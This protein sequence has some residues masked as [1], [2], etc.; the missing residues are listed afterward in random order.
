MDP[1][2][3]QNRAPTE[4]GGKEHWTG[5]KGERSFSHGIKFL[6]SRPTEAPGRDRER[7]QEPPRHKSRRELS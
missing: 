5:W 6:N 4:D 7:D 1:R 3:P 2:T